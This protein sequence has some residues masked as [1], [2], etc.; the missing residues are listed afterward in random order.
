MQGKIQINHVSEALKNKAYELGFSFCGISPARFLEEE[1]PRLESWLQ[2]GSH[3]KMTYMANYFDKRLDP[4]LLVDDA[5][6]VVS[7]AFN[8]YPAQFQPDDSKYKISKYAYGED[9]HHVIRE[10]LKHLESFLRES[11]GDI[12]IR[13]FVDSAP[14]LERAWAVLSGL[15]WIGRNSMLITRRNG[16]FLFL[17]EIITDI[18]LEY[19]RS[20]GGNYCG[21]CTRCV[22]ACPTGAITDFTIDANRCISYL[23]IELKDEVSPAPKGA[24]KE[25]IF[26]CDICQ[27]VCPWNRFSTPHIENRFNPK[28]GLFELQPY[29]WEQLEE[30]KFKQMFGHSAIKR[31]GLSGLKRNIHFFKGS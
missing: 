22:D 19:D 1:S 6:S 11:N 25:W 7:L 14:I 16:S 26:G 21:D 3:G 12:N 15:G 27:D 24:Y 17:A 18:E 9:Y 20:F 8:Y 28:P 5:K 23:T 2:K 30:D 31:T 10:K 4:R 29:E 13:S